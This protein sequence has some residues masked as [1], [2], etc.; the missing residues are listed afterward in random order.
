MYTGN[1][2]STPMAPMAPVEACLKCYSNK[3]IVMLLTG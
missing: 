2:V 3:I 1:N